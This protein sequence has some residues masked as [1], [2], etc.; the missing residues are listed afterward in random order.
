MSR[1]ARLLRSVP[2]TNVPAWEKKGE[3]LGVKSTDDASAD[4]EQVRRYRVAKYRV[5][6]AR[7]G[8]IPTT[9]DKTVREPGDVA[10]L[11]A[12]LVADI[13]QESFWLILLDGRNKVAGITLISLGSLTAALVHPRE[14][15]KP[16]IAGSA[17]ALVLLHNHPSGD[18]SPSA[19]DIA[20]TRRLSEVGELVGIK[21]LDHLVIGEGGS[22][23]SLADDGVL[24]G[25]R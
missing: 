19:E 16:A 9:W 22:Y 8:S 15:F 3:Q 25:A 10:R 18:P 6:L 20:L 23:R 11:M 2:I 12:P 7:E 17:A 5:A 4:P 21:V 24:G 14:V 13:S 1:G